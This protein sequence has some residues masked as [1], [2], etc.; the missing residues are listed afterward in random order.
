MTNKNIPKSIAR[1]IHL[2]AKSDSSAFSNQFTN[3]ITAKDFYRLKESHVTKLSCSEFLN[4]LCS[5]FSSCGSIIC[6]SEL[7]RLL[8][9]SNRTT[10]ALRY[11]QAKTNGINSDEYQSI[12]KDILLIKIESSILF[13]GCLTS[14]FLA[15]IRGNMK[16]LDF[17]CPV[18]PDYSYIAKEAGRYEYTFKEL[19]SGIGLV[20]RRAV[21]N[22]KVI[23]SFAEQLK[24]EKKHLNISI[25]VGDF[26]ANEQNCISLNESE[27]SFSRKCFESSLAIK[28]E[29]K[30]ANTGVFTNLCGGLQ[31]WPHILKFV[32]QL[33]KI[34]TYD[35]L[36]S[37]YP[38]LNHEKSLLSRIPLYRR[39]FEG[40]TDLKSVFVSQ[41]LEY[42]TMGFIVD[43][44][45]NM[46]SILIASDHMVMR[47]YYSLLCPLTIF[48]STLRY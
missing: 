43:C 13:S 20:A 47:Q 33:S 3:Y 25:L 16:P 14:D 23:L 30:I 8:Q 7:K 6:E 38:T 46:N 29:V 2:S 45:R 18:C 36:V 44:Q 9:L 37:N 17:V 12:M 26:E 39:W 4:Q 21:N 42:A 19:G 22:V 48:G 15:S 32:K 10:V 41:I 34:E 40:N 35:D 5:F 24:L 1:Q 27:S 31:E 28:E 11:L